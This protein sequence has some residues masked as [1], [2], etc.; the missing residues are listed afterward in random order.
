MNIGDT[1]FDQ[2]NLIPLILNRVCRKL[3]RVSQLASHLLDCSKQSW[4]QL[5][6]RNIRRLLDSAFVVFR[7]EVN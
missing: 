3:Q 6:S 1:S 2:V 4:E 5:A 7:G